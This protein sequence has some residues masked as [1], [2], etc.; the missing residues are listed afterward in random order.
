MTEGPQAAA[1]D[2]EAKSAEAPTADAPASIA[3]GR[4]R[5][6]DP[7]SVAVGRRAAWIATSFLTLLLAGVAWIL[8]ASNAVPP[9]ALWTIRLAI[10]CVLGLA[11]WGSHVWPALRYH[12]TRY[13]LDAVGMEIKRG[14]VW[15]NVSSVPRARVQHTDVSQ[16]P[17]QRRF[18]LAT[19]TIHTAGL[20]NASI[21]LAGVAKETALAIRAALAHEG[22][23]G[24]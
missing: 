20:V 23:D 11:G 24:V 12:R 3:D 2:P 8:D 7:R 6:V 21:M 16:G 9:L 22:G 1:R 19:L 5:K 13:R 4:W 10:V 15:R 14:V 17:L 18:G